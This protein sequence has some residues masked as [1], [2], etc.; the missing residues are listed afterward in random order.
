MTPPLPPPPVQL[1]GRL[2]V[3]VDIH[4]VT[5]SVRF[6]VASQTA[7]VSATVELTIDGP[8]GCPV[9]DL[10][11]DIDAAALDGR[12]LPPEALG[13][14]DMGAGNE[15]RMRV[16]DVACEGGSSH[17]LSLRYRLGTPEATGSLPVD[18]SPTGDGVSWDLFM[19]DL[20]PGRYLEMWLPAN[21]CTTS[22]PS[23]SKSRSPG[24]R[25]R[26]CCSLMGLLSSTRPG[27]A[28]AC[29]TPV[30]LL[31]FPRCWCWLPRTRSRHSRRPCVLEASRPG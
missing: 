14:A 9:F 31:P 27:M 19:S 21:L 1:D 26:M 8:T 3:P 17:V 22:S 13:Y 10:R 18:W 28:G 7:E 25:G 24:Q 29:V 12:P 5:A 4:Q 30:P 11:Q 6:D 23:S 2:A 15:A 20:E 16:V